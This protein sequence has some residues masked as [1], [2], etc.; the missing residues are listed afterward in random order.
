MTSLGLG[1]L[2]AQRLPMFEGQVGHHA[3]GP[4]SA[5]AHGGGGAQYGA[6]RLADASHLHPAPRWVPWQGQVNPQKAFGSL[7]QG[8]DK[9]CSW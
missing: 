3:A 4:R 2:L 7:G 6:G 1:L 5:S 8:F 9:M